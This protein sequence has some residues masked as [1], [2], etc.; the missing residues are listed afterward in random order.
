MKAPV[1][2]LPRVTRLNGSGAGLK[3]KEVV[4]QMGPVKADGLDGSGDQLEGDRRCGSQEA[5]QQASNC[6]RITPGEWRQAS[7]QV[8]QRNGDLH[9]CIAPIAL[10]GNDAQGSLGSHGLVLLQRPVHHLVRPCLCLDPP[11]NPR[12]AQDDS[13]PRGQLAEPIEQ[14]HSIGSIE[15]HQQSPEQDTLELAFDG[16]GQGISQY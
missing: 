8:N 7:G 4:G 9:M 15:V 10:N 16:H 6:G 3:E 14:C 5:P 13:A 12:F 2:H 11:T 1:P